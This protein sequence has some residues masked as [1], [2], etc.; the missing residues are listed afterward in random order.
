M[1]QKVFFMCEHMAF[2]YAVVRDLMKYNSGIISDY[3]LWNNGFDGYAPLSNPNIGVVV[4]QLD[5][6]EPNIGTKFI[7]TDNGPLGIIF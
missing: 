6:Y 4:N 2:E 1:Q 3:I 7:K 5:E